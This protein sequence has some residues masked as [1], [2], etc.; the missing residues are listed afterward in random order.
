MTPSDTKK[1]T[2]SDIDKELK[3]FVTDLL[4][5]AEFQ[6]FVT[7]VSGQIKHKRKYFS[8]VSIN[9]KF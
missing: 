8:Q 1:M 3:Q 6:A 5:D 4:P 9:N 2:C 7:V